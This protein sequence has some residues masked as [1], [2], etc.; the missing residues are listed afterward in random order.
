MAEIGEEAE[1]AGGGPE[2]K[3]DRVLRVMRDHE[4]VHRQVAKIEA[5]ARLEEAAVKPGLS[6][7]LNRIFRRAIAINRQV[8]FF[9]ESRHAVDVVGMLVSDEDRSEHLR[10]AANLCHSLANLAQA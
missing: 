8:K 9:V 4:S 2:Q 7:V 3:S 10:R 1:I 6:Q 5:C